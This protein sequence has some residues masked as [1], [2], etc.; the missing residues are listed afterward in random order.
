MKTWTKLALLLTLLVALT[1]P[2]VALASDQYDDEIVFGNTFTLE[3]G[4]TLN[5][6]LIVFGGVAMLEDG[7]TVR[8]DLVVFGGTVDVEGRITGNLVGLGGPITLGESAVVEGDVVSMGASVSQDSGAVVHG[9][10]VDSISGPFPLVFPATIR[11]LPEGVNLPTF[12][13][14]FNPIVELVWFIVKLFLWAALAV[15]VVLF[16]PDH[17]KRTARTVV[18]QPLPTG[19]LGCLSAILLP[20]LLFFLVITICLIPVAIIVAIVA[21]LAWAFGLIALGLEVGKRLTQ[22]F[23][24][25][26]APAA[27]AGLG[28]F[29]LM[30]VIGGVGAIVPCIGWIVPAL[31]GVV[32]F[33]AVLLTRFGTQTYPQEVPYETIDVEEELPPPSPPEE[34]P[35]AVS[36]DVEA[37][38]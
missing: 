5:G 8:G 31:V 28:T 38:E 15:L 23:K 30:L 18:D 25:D 17:T 35:S 11:S 37:E 27:S 29:T 34:L 26:W 32:G 14:R 33:G 10:V 36:P 20:F 1:W 9:N 24:W 12:T 22:A 21:A 4:E 16:L 2:T 6:N 13:P 19:G 7:S 3:S